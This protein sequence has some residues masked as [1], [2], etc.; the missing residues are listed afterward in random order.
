[1]ENTLYLF[2]GGKAEG[3]GD[4]HD[5]GAGPINPDY[6]AGPNVFGTAFAP[7]EVYV[8]RQGKSVS[9]RSANRL[10]MRRPGITKT[11]VQSESVP[12]HDLD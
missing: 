10:L 12:K 1:M 3:H 2:G 9:G 6:W 11:A 5:A 4:C 8:L 7:H